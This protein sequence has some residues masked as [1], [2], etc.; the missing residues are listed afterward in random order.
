MGEVWQ[1]G[2]RMIRGDHEEVNKV[3]RLHARSRNDVN[4]R[5][6][7]AA[8]DLGIYGLESG[9]RTSVMNL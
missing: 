7:V 8:T 1:S 3:A 4:T 2:R 6:R 5:L 9:A